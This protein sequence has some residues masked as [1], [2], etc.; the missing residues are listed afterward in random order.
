MISS[1]NAASTREVFHFIC[2]VP[3]NGRLYELDGLKPYPIDHGL[4]EQSQHWTERFKEI[5][6]E[7]LGANSP[8]NISSTSQSP[9]FSFSS[10]LQ[11]QSRGT[12]QDI[13]FNLMSVVPDKIMLYE[14]NL[15]ILNA[16]CE[17]LRKVIGNFADFSEKIEIKK[18][19]NDVNGEECG[20]Y[21]MKYEKSEKGEF[22]WMNKDC[23]LINYEI[24]I[25]KSS[26]VFN[27]ET[28]MSDEDFSLAELSEIE[29]K[30]CDDMQSF[31][32]KL[33]EEIEKRNKYKVS[34][35]LLFLG[36]FLFSFDFL[37]VFKVDAQ[38]RKHKYDE[39]IVTF[40]KMLVENGQLSE[41]IQNQIK[42]T[43]RTNISSSVINSG[44]G[45]GHCSSSYSHL[46]LPKKMKKK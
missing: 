28:K 35:K 18:E 15:K 19:N 41:L 32:A 6:S 39:F 43:K 45:N 17:R 26:D 14:N 29:K 33:K 34:L 25:V 21:R 11:S 7:R 10:V 38:R 4:I 22:S 16:N 2:F 1:M 13:R 37:I 5:I 8:L 30:L 27:G 20:F 42:K 46:G 36:K 40:V 23:D 3:I 31:E 9:F 24:E 12:K 44:G